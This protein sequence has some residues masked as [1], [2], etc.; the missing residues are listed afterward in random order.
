MIVVVMVVRSYLEN[1]ANAKHKSPD[2]INI[3]KPINL[4]VDQQKPGVGHQA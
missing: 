3:P 4:L 1:A 2:H